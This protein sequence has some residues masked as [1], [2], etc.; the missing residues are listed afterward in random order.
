MQPSWI[1]L[2]FTYEIRRYDPR[3]S[4]WDNWAF[5]FNLAEAIVWFAIAALVLNRWRQFR[6]TPEEW[7]YAG[8][9]FAFGLTDVCEAFLLQTWLLWI[10]ALIL[11]G[12]LSCRRRLH[13]R[14]YPGWKTY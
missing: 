3:G 9:F 14:H 8:L 13:Q 12:I 4:V 6:R 11:A 2:L 7:L 1:S 5:Y 10:K